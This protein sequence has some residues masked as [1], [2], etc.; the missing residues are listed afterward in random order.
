M[1]NE[2]SARLVVAKRVPH[3]VTLINE[4]SGVVALVRYGADELPRC[5]FKGHDDGEE[6][7][8]GQLVAAAP[9]QLTH[10][11]QA[12]SLAQRFEVILFYEHDLR[13]VGPGLYYPGVVLLYPLLKAF[14]LDRLFLF[15]HLRPRGLHRVTTRNGQPSTRA[16]SASSAVTIPPR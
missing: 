3:V 15:A 6:V 14:V 1:A 5:Q 13:R 12:H 4:V 9:G 7:L 10:A 2:I 16:I 8:P 11:G